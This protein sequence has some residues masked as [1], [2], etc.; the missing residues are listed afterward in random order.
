M[1]ETVRKQAAV[2][3]KINDLTLPGEIVLFGS[4][5]MASFPIYELINRC[6]F[7]NAVYNRSIKG[8]TVSEALDIVEGCVVKIKPHKLFVALGEEDEGEL[9]APEAYARLVSLFRA[10]LPECELFLI[11]LT[12][13]GQYVENFNQKIREL[14]DGRAVRYVDFGI[15]PTTG[16]A[17]YKARFMQLSRFFWNKPLTMGDAFALAEL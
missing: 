14:C 3:E 5:Y 15:A 1:K 7:E 12:G 11:G 2:L 4:T 17:Q 6:K 10:R 13:Q 16:V 9:N 8:L